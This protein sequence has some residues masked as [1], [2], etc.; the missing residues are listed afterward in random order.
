MLNGELPYSD[1]ELQ[2]VNPASGFDPQKPFINRDPRFAASILCD[3]VVWMGRETETF[4]NGKDSRGSSIDAWNAT[5]TGYYMKKFLP[6]DIPPS[7]ST[8]KPTS[9]W[10]FFRYAEILLNYA[11][12]KFEMGDE[13]TARTNINRIRTRA[14]MPQINASGEELR[15]KIYHERRI[16][17]VF[18]GHR[19]YDVRRWK[20]ANQTEKVSLKAMKIIKNADGSKTYAITKLLDRN[21]LDQHY[22]LP[23]PRAEIDR[24]LGSLVQN[25]GYN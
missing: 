3:G 12:A 24:S 4:E 19:F 21:F 2:V 22:L 14:G 15:K 9:P 17:L 1:Q 11:E 20:I 6:S 16:E 18:E 10:I 25:T 8:L 5:L 13:N 23:I 7:G